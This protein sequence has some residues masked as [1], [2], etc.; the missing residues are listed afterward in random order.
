LLDDYLQL[1]RD[2]RTQNMATLKE[3][4]SKSQEK[5]L[6]TTTFRP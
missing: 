3:L 1:N 2:L 5:F 6:W 4:A